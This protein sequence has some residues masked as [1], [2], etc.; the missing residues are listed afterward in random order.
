MKK[1]WIN[2]KKEPPTTDRDVIVTED[3]TCYAIAWYNIGYDG[4][5]ISSDMLY[6]EINEGICDINLEP[7]VVK[8]W[9]E[10]PGEDNEHS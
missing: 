3:H 7:G 1:T 4:W 5:H 9:A 8:E 10:I 2:A 6:A